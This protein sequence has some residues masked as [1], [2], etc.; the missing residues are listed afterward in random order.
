MLQR[1]QNQAGSMSHARGG[2]WGQEK[3]GWRETSL[4]RWYL[5][6][7]P[8]TGPHSRHCTGAYGH[9]VGAEATGGSR[10]GRP[11]IKS[12]SVTYES[13]SLGQVTCL[14][15]SFILLRYH[16]EMRGVASY[17][18]GWLWDRWDGSFLERLAPC[19]DPES[20]GRGQGTSRW[21]LGRTWY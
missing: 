15:P 7:V 20:H 4:K 17:L 2:L 6:V 16:M 12:S 10:L 9:G 21:C 19:L 11:R 18:I 14:L 13:W 8:C 3:G 1:G 5:H